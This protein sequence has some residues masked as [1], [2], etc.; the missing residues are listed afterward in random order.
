MRRVDAGTKI[1]VWVVPADED[2]MIAEH[3]M[4]MV[5]EGQ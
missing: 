3:V 4:R 5:R 1:Q 2:L